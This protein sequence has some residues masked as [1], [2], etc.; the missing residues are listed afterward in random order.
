MMMPRSELFYLLR[1]FSWKAER[2]RRMP[3]D[4]KRTIIYRKVKKGAKRVMSFVSDFFTGKFFRK[5]SQTE[6][7][8]SFT[9]SV[10]SSLTKPNNDQS[11]FSEKIIGN[12]GRLRTSDNSQLNFPEEKQI[13]NYDPF[14]LETLR[15]E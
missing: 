7:G 5:R 2:G 11:D 14:N 4:K 12:D 1:W 3:G 9:S 13:D 10:S 6:R 15:E 8:N